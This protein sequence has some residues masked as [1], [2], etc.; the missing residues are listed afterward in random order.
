MYNQYYVLAN[1][2]K[3]GVGS[4]SCAGSENLTDAMS[5]TPTNLIHGVQLANGFNQGLLGGRA[6]AYFRRMDKKV[7]SFEDSSGAFSG[8]SGVDAEDMVFLVM[9]ISPEM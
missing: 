3:L 9:L 1:P 2:P 5:L 6:S 8:R 4:K 7:L